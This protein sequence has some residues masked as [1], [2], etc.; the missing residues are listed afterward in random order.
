VASRKQQRLNE[1]AQSR[2]FRNYAEQRKML[3]GANWNPDS[4]R[5]EIPSEAT[6]YSRSAID[7]ALGRKGT[8]LNELSLARWL[9]FQAAQAGMSRSRYM[10]LYPE[11]VREIVEDA[12]PFYEVRGEE[13]YEE[14][15]EPGG[16]FAEFLEVNAGRDPGSTVPVGRTEMAR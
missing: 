4:H 9:D 3:K 8:A 10:R 13:A 6:S 1:N 5:F 11:R 15:H 2:G 12:R 7:I 16:Q 14:M